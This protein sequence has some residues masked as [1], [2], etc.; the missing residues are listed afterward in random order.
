[1][2]FYITLA[3]K[4]L[5]RNKIRTLISVGAI[6]L[7]ILIVINLKGMMDGMLDSMVDLNIK[8]NSGHVRII[9]EIYEKK[10]RLLSLSYPIDGFNGEGVNKMAK[11]I[12][13]IEGVQ[14][15]LPRIKFGAAVSTG[16]K[17]VQM[18]GWGIDV[19]KDI[20][21]TE[22]KDNIDK[23]RVI[24]ENKKEIMVG[25]KLLDKMGKKVGDSVTIVYS[26]SWGSFKGSTFEIVGE[27]G[28][29]LKLLNE[30][31]FFLPLDIA[32][33]ILEM[34]NMS[35]ELLVITE[36]Y[37]NMDLTYNKIQETFEE[38]DS[39]DRYKLLHWKYGNPFLEYMETGEKIYNILYIFVILLASIVMVNTM[40]MIVK[41][42][43]REIGML[44]AMGFRSRDVLKIFLTEGFMLGVFGS[45]IGILFGGSLLKYVSVVGI[46]YSEVMQDMDPDILMELVIYPSFGVS[47]IIFSFI[48]GVIVTGIT[49]IIPARKA[50]KLNPNDALRYE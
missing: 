48:M 8:Y 28:S 30:M 2:F 15:T 33:D 41:E 22:I 34:P 9:D 40:I 46:D 13:D 25:S 44:T 17:L 42:R 4:N 5:F 36:D 35:T 29:S 19:K 49:A 50:A 38:N 12:E 47:Q 11:K 7:S 37:R 1:M 27:I 14:S 32:Q 21:F 43:T 18:M 10:E 45:A 31:S 24:Q 16:D 6:A 20:K 3:T 39:N 26:T 23:G